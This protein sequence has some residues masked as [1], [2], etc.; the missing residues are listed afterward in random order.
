MAAHGR[1]DERRVYL[2]QVRLKIDGE[3][4]RNP[5]AHEPI[6]SRDLFEAAQIAHPQ[7]PR[8]PRPPP[9]GGTRP[10]RLPAGTR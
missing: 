8:H 5:N 10:L 3:V 9:L 7:Q 1:R 6:L 4:V 2:G